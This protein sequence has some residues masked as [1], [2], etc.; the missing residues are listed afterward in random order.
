MLIGHLEETLHNGQPYPKRQIQILLAEQE[1]SP[2]S[3]T[4]PSPTKEMPI[5][6]VRLEDV[7]SDKVQLGTSRVGAVWIDRRKPQFATCHYD[8]G[9]ECF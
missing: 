1:F 3:R 8:Q 2:A 9:R 4:S 6:I 5:A 7:G